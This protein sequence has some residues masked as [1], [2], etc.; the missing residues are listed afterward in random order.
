SYRV[1][2][3]P[4]DDTRQIA[5]AINFEIDGQFPLPIEQLTVDHLAIKR[6]DGR[7]RALVVAVKRASVEHVVARFALADVDLRVVTTGALALAQAMATT[8]TPPLPVGIDP[9]MQPVTLLVDCGDKST[10]LVAIG[11]DGPVAARGLRR[12][13]RQ[14]VRELAKTWRLDKSAA[15]L[16]LERDGT[17]DDPAI[18]R[19]MQPLLREIEHTRQWL[20]AEVGCQVVEVRLAGGGAKLRGLGPWL[21]SELGIEVGPV[22]PK[23]SGALRS[24]QGRDWTGALVAMGTA[25]AT[26]RRPLI[27]L[28]DAFEGGNEGQWIQQHMSSL[29]ALGV[30]I[31]AFA[32]VDSM[33]RVRAAER[34]RDAYLAELER[35]SEV[36]FGEALSTGVEV[37]AK[38]LSVDGG[39]M[40][41]QIPERGALEVLEMLT[42]VSAPKGGRQP[43]AGAIDSA[44]LPPGFNISVGP[45]GQ[46]VV[47]GPDGQQVPLDSSGQPMLDPTGGS[48]TAGVPP[49]EDE[50]GEDGGGA[51][52]PTA[53]P[54]VTDPNA[55]ILADDELVFT[56]IDI[57]ELKLEIAVQATR[58]TAQDRLAVKL[59][60]ISC[61]QKITKGKVTDRQERKSF[62]MILDHNC[63]T[64]NIANEGAAEAT[65][66]VDAGAAAT[67]GD[68]DIGEEDDGE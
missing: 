19:A 22:Q 68:D 51:A 6:G 41:S 42:K 46:Q 29:L 26:G 24:V 23:E 58:T 44:G 5:Q 25:L 30:A 10:D 8:P 64:G 67:G 38:L 34:E 37:Q 17:I 16:A 27:Q 56:A 63:Y 59:D 12:G 45:D 39:D 9:S 32:G 57:R 52:G 28:H 3:F 15:E 33:V 66:V 40:N 43:A 13:G 35:E 53:P 4:F 20:R 61:I 65:E 55:G 60:Q 54:L 49:G 50:G 11:A 62:E 18:R 1:L 7:G 31:L 48:A 14:L 47:I 21:A 36:V 2:S